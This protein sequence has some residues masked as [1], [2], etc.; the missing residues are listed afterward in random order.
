M[1][2]TYIYAKKRYTSILKRSVKLYRELFLLKLISQKS[3]DEYLNAN[4]TTE[5][6]LNFLLELKV[7][8]NTENELIRKYRKYYQCKKDDDP[9]ALENGEISFK[10]VDSLI[11]NWVKTNPANKYQTV[12]EDHFFIK[13]DAFQSFY[14]H[15][16]YNR[17]CHYC[18]ISENQIQNLFEKDEI[19]TKRWFKRGSRME[20]DRMNPNQ[21]YKIDNLALCCYWC[22]N[23]KTDEFTD[24]EFIPI[25]ESFSLLWNKRLA[26]HNLA[27]IPDPPSIK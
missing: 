7:N 8:Q 27:L 10:K 19:N 4:G 25:G 13:I 3:E 15:D 24:I 12:F 9:I 6:F 11:K 1:A 22:N 17:N 5:A 21:N 16:D 2:P 26:K 23:A 14:K 18:R 20:V